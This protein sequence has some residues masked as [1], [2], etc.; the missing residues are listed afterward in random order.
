MYR[1][2]NDVPVS[3]NA[4]DNCGAK[5]L[6]CFMGTSIVMVCACAIGRD[7]WAA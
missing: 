2:D 3:Q 6:M 5:G 1:V 7:G 4:G